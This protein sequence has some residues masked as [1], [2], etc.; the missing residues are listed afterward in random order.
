MSIFGSSRISSPRF[1]RGHLFYPIILH[2]TALRLI[3]FMVETV[4]GY[5]FL[6]AAQSCVDKRYIVLYM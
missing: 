5:M 4:S 1:E 3:L 6:Y 2:A